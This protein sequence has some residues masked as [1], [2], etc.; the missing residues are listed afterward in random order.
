M[1][2]PPSQSSDT[3]LIS[4]LR[5]LPS[6]QTLQIVDVL[7]PHETV[8]TKD[9]LNQFSAHQ[10]G[11]RHSPFLPHLADLTL[12]VYGDRIDQAALVDAVKSRWLPDEAHASETGVD[13][14]RSI[15]VIF[16]ERNSPIDCIET[17]NHLRDAGL[18]VFISHHTPSIWT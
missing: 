17:L 6:L 4:F 14:L 1:I 8:L 12:K 16:R 2:R 5:L 10:R 7:K 3:E 18:K 11:F 15:S 9:I 13:C